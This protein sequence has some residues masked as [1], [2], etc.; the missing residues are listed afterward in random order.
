MIG[1][2]VT[3]RE[4]EFVSRKKNHPNDKF[5]SPWRVRAKCESTRIS[6]TISFILS[7]NTFNGI[8]P[9]FRNA[10]LSWVTTLVLGRVRVRWLKTELSIQQWE[11]ALAYLVQW[12]FA[13]EVSTEELDEKNTRLWIIFKKIQFANLYTFRSILCPIFSRHQKLYFSRWITENLGNYYWRSDVWHVSSK[14]CECSLVSRTAWI[15]DMFY[16][17]ST[18]RMNKENRFFIAR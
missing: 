10:N 13:V 3:R 16:D 12:N 9:Y 1:Q 6:N 11:S 8:C 4:T 14:F 7:W 5:E 17:R 15:S 2:S 18:I